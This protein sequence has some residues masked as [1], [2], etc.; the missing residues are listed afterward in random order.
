LGSQK[1]TERVSFWPQKLTLKVSFWAQ[2][3]DILYEN[4]LGYPGIC[5][6]A[7]D[8]GVLGNLGVGYTFVQVQI[9]KRKVHHKMFKTKVFPAFISN[10]LLKKPILL[11]LHNQIILRRLGNWD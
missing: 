5:S 2:K 10:R 6:F 3:Q 8:D 4:R 9:F 1:L 7:D 11:E